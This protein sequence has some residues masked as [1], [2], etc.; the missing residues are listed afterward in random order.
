MYVFY[1]VGAEEGAQACSI[2]NGAVCVL[3]LL[4]HSTPT[5]DYKDQLPDLQE[6]FHSSIY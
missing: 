6:S 2:T 4:T 3:K 1:S 5:R